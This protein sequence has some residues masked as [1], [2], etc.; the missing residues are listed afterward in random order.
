VTALAFLGFEEHLV[1]KNLNPR[2]LLPCCR[3]RLPWSPTSKLT[4]SRCYCHQCHQSI[5]V[6][7]HSSLLNISILRHRQSNDKQRSASLTHTYRFEGID[8]SHPLPAIISTMP[9]W[10]QEGSA[11]GFSPWTDSATAHS[12][13]PR[14]VK[15]F[16]MAALTPHQTYVIH[17]AT[18]T[19]ASM[20]ILAT[21]ITSFWFFRMRRSFRHE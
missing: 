13:G 17:V 5:P 6:G 9:P 18:L 3:G 20:S 7:H 12:L 4:I 15:Q 10:L 14:R 11:L 2:F 8:D 19:V 21:I 1:H 16:T